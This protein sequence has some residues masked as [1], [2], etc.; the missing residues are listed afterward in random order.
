MTT[1]L[2][3]G[4]IYIYI[5]LILIF[6]SRQQSFWEWLYNT[7]R[8]FVIIYKQKLVRENNESGKELGLLEVQE[9]YDSAIKT[10]IGIVV[11]VITVVIPTIPKLVKFVETKM[12]LRN[13]YT[14]RIILE[15]NQRSTRR[16]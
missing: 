11:P 16:G 12:G 10:A 14:V 15:S 8:A 7:P 9:L 1:F 13:S 2:Q 6:F 3:L 4:V 5:F